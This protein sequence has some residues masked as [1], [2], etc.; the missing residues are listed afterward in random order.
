MIEG[1]VMPMSPRISKILSQLFLALAALLVSSG[2][3]AKDVSV[4]DLSVYAN[5]E[6][7]KLAG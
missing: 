6:E 2:A 3:A 4:V 7:A 5:A 1:K